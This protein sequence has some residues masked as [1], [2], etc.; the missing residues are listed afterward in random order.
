MSS[1]MSGEIEER[2]EWGWAWREARMGLRD[3]RAEEKRVVMERRER[4]VKTFI[5][6]QAMICKARERTVRG[7]RPRK[8]SLCM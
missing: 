8:V 6:C 4:R 3:E 1:S 7:Q 2:L 5:A